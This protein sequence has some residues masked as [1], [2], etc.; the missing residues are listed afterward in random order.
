MINNLNALQQYYN[1]GAT[2]NYD[3]R[4]NALRKLRTIL[5]KYENEIYQALYNDLKKGKEE[6]YVTELGMVLHEI[7]FTLSRLKKWMKPVSVGTNIFNMPASSKIYKQPIGIVFI[8]APWNYPLQLALLPLVGAIAA[9]NCVALKPSELAPHTALLL[10][11]ILSEA[12]DAAHVYTLQG[13]GALVVNEALDNFNFNHI[14]YTGSTFVGKLIY[15]KA[16]EKLTPVTLELGGKSPCI[17]TQS[18]HIKTT[19]KRITLAKFSNCGQ[20]CVTPDY[21][22]V[23]ASKK[24]ELI[25]EI[26]KCIALF[27]TD[28]PAE[29][30]NYG[31]LINEKRFD[32]VASFLQQGTIVHGGKTNKKNLFI[33]PTLIT[34]ISFD[35]PIMQ[36]EIFG[37][38]MP[39]VTFNTNEEALAIIAKN[40]N[41][42][43]LYLYT[44]SK[45]DETFF[46]NQ[47]AFGGGCI[48]N[49]AF[50]LTNPK[51]PFGGIGNSGLG[52]YHGKKS[53]ETFS[54][55]K[56]IMRTPTWFDPFVKYPPFEGRLGFFKKLLG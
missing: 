6:A 14:F 47:V 24:E 11:K 55:S 54:H 7:N 41:P 37:P 3:A 23:H 26:K 13:D 50:H 44:K 22:L 31:K 2:K 33:E 42:L 19:A 10:E 35:S 36:Q 17:V 29:S 45:A 43:A 28:K 25:A 49:S 4:C 1:T 16:A 48:N 20:M 12:F 40:P 5:L 38:I 32:D 56:S 51:L 34:D 39:I 52:S 27:F 53:F 8:I 18:A 46:I 21:V 15:K 9:G 30:N